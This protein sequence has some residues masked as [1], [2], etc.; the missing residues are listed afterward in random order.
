MTTSYSTWPI[1]L[2]NYNLPPWL[3]MKPENLI[4]STIIL[5]PE[6]PKNNI[7]IFMQPL[8]EELK[9]LWDIGIETYGAFTNQNFRLRTSVLWTISDFPGYAML[10][11]WRTKGKFSCP[12]CHYETSS[13]YL[14]HSK[15]M[16]YMNHRKFLVPEHKW[17]FDK[18]RFN[19]EVEM[20]QPPPI[21]TGTNVVEL[22]SDYQNEFGK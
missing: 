2:V 13:M 22:L 10:S 20:G 11:G 14:K 17:R 6:S 9:E 3:C 7:D 16:C 21:L 18:K 4:L 1:I 19:G 5:D 12:K 8:I 15:K